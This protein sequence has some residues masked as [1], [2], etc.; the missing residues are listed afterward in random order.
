MPWRRTGDQ[1][2]AAGK[3][4]Q[5]AGQTPPEAPLAGRLGLIQRGFQGFQLGELDRAFVAGLTE[6]P[7]DEPQRNFGGQARKAARVIGKAAAIAA[8]T[9]RSAAARSLALTSAAPPVAAGGRAAPAGPRSAPRPRDRPS[10]RAAA[11]G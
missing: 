2:L 11:P 6:R 8:G 1:D 4:H 3:R 9:A 5:R 10:G 7:A